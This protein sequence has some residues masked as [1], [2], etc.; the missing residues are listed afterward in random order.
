M[1]GINF[2]HFHIQEL[3]ESLIRDLNDNNKYNGKK[4]HFSYINNGII[5]KSLMICCDGLS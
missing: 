4:S 3:A 2:I 1:S 5:L